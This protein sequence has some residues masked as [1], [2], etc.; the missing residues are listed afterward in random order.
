MANFG[1]ADV[2]IFIASAT[3]ANATVTEISTYCDTIS[4]FT[5]E[6]L[7][8]QTDGFGDTWQE[9]LWT[10]IRRM[11]DIVVEGFYDDV[12]TGPI[13]HYG[14]LSALGSIRN[15]EIN[16]AGGSSD[17]L[18]GACIVMKIDRLPKRGELTRWRGTFRPTGVIGTAS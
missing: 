6:A 3:G 9:H 14:N 8:Q 7:T 11:D 2:H 17:L 16:V 15:F 1:Q 18:N 5:V 12:A 13:A 4:G 10:S